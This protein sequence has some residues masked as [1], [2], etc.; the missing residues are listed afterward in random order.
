MKTFS[1]FWTGPLGEEIKKAIAAEFGESTPYTMSLVGEDAEAVVQAVNQGIDSHLEACF[2]PDRGDRYSREER[3]FTATEDGPRW[4]TGDKVVHTVTLGCS[5][6]P[7]SLPV[8]IR[9]LLESELEAGPSLASSICESLE[10][11]LI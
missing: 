10:I 3:S 11:E 6:S 4:K 7:Q 9:R 2:V 8:L 1:A 5:V